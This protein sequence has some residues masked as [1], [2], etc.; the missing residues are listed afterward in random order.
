M[1]RTNLN[2]VVDLLLLLVCGGLLLT[3]LV[4]RFI[5]PPGTGMRHAAEHGHGG[6]L[7]LFGLGRH[8]FGDIHFWLAV[9]AIS[10]FVLHVALHWSWVCSVLRSWFG[11]EKVQPRPINHRRRNVA[12]GGFLVALAAGFTIFLL[13]SRAVV[14]RVA[15]MDAAVEIEDSEPGL[16]KSDTGRGKSRSGGQHRRIGRAAIR[17]QMTLGEVEALTGVSAEEIIRELKLPSSISR[18][19]RL[20]R[21][22]RR[23]GLE[24]EEIREAISRCLKQADK[25][26]PSK[27][28][29]TAN[30]GSS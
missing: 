4:I 26:N 6:G 30:S 25:I 17:G 27:N 21:L 14:H 20:G 16:K 18:D 1:R 3:G 11:G 23:Y 29:D 9:V 10:L 22:G 5:L 28:G 19:S 15:S 2:F 12:G 8:D 7:T 24:M 13:Y